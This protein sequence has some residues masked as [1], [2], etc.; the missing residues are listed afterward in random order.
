MWLTF[1]ETIIGIIFIVHPSYFVISRIVKNIII[2]FVTLDLLLRNSQEMDTELKF[3]LLTKI[4]KEK[5][6]KKTLSGFQ[7]TENRFVNK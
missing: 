7:N 3:F 4:N 5:Y 6:L 1:I 2:F